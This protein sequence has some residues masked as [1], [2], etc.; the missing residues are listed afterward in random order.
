VPTGTVTF[1]FSDIEGSTRL[2]QELGSVGYRELLEQHQRLLRAAFAAHGGVER[3]TEGDSFFVVFRDAPSAVAA[4]AE[5]QRSLGT[6]SWP[7]GREVRVRIGLHTGEGIRGGD[8]YIGVDVNRAA[9]IASAGHGGQVLISESTRALAERQ[10]P[11]GVAL[12]DLGGHRLK[13][14]A[15]AERVYQVIVDG[16]PSEFPPLRSEPS[17]A[18][19]LPPR[20]TSFVGRESELADVQRLL[21]TSRLVTLVGPGGSG[22]TS[23][24]IECARTVAEEFEDGA[25]FAAL[26]TVSDPEL[27][28]SQ[29]VGSLGLRDVRGQSAGESLLENL[30]GRQMLLVLDNFEQVIE[31]SSFVGKVLAVAS[32]VKVLVTSRAPLHVTGEQLFPV[33][34]LALPARPHPTSAAGDQVDPDALLSAP[35]VRL[36]VDRAQQVQPTFRLTAENGAA[37]VEICE[38]LD[39]LP[40]GIELAAAR[41]SLLGAV[42]I[43]DRLSQRAGLPAAPNRDVPE[44]QRTLREAIGWSHDLLEP[45]ARA[46]F[47][48]LSVFVGGCR[49]QEAEA[50]CRGASEVG[51]EVVDTLSALVDQSLVT[52]SQTDDVVRYAMLETIREYA[53]ERLAERDEA[54]EFRRRHALVFLALAEANALAF[55]TRGS[56]AIARWFAAEEANLQAVVRWSIETGAAETGLLLIAALQHYWRLDGRLVERRSIA[57]EVLD[58]PGADLPSRPRMRALEAAG[59]LFYDS[60]D[61]GRAD[62]LYRAQL[63]VARKIGDQQGATDALFNLAF[64]EDWRDR[65]A[66][67]FARVEELVASYRQLGDERSLA[68]TEVLRAALLLVD[69]ENEALRVLE[70]VHLRFRALDDVPY[71]AMAA[72]MIGGAYLKQGDS[73]A[74]ARWFVETLVVLREIGDMPRLAMLL[75]IEAMA[76]LELG[77]PESAAVILGASEALSRRYGLQRP[78]GLE[79]TLAFM[80]PRSRTRAALDP[81]SFEAAMRRGREMT[82]E[83][84]VAYVL[85][86]AKP[87]L[88]G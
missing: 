35:A 8:D 29:I 47:A 86:M 59:S 34:P 51:G 2:V 31:A 40:L 1:L 84:A 48:R 45:V 76:A 68:R 19:H 49:I 38:R 81:E 58:I 71:E 30:S 11:I 64:T 52:A 57:L 65:P 15:V 17:R 44:R 79:Q 36:F 22:K 55:G 50:V 23:L 5:A 67:A 7:Q 85:E 53:D 26:D 37:I 14:L 10:L 13:G 20:L 33:H 74:A 16:L 21:A 60:G 46:L 41:V 66:E 25:W 83:E 12:R 27:I 82:F 63:E 4:A 42:G 62:S 70:A 28:P 56:G 69:N 39:G 80:D 3:A 77:R 87:L 18:A 61:N 75:P 78:A 54:A 6:A 9:R 72:S 32:E 88:D 43:R 73:R 24:A